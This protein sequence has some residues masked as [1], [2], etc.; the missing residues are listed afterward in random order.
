M[1]LL[2]DNADILQTAY[3]TSKAAINYL[4]QLIASQY[5]EQGVRCN[6]VLP[7][8]TDTNAANGNLD[9]DFLKMFLSSIPLKRMGDPQD[10]AEAVLFFASEMSSYVTGEL[11]E[12]AGGFGKP[13]PLYSIIKNLNKKSE[14]K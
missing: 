7:G 11:L 10:I 5:A 13:T 2:K 12:V 6:A 8:L 1:C 3:G 4:T 9:P 14:Y